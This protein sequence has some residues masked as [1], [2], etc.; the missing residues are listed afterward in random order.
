MINWIISNNLKIC[1]DD[2]DNNND[3]EIN[4]KEKLKPAAI[5]N[6]QPSRNGER[7]VFLAGLGKKRTARLSRHRTESRAESTQEL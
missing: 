7:C 5:F 2:G 6:P 1:N 4:R 3:N